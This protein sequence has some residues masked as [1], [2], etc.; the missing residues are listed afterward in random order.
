MN[1]RVLLFDIDGTLIRCGG[2]GGKSLLAAAALEFGLE[3][4]SPVPIHGRTDLGIV[5]QLL[6]ENGIDCTET[7]RHRLCERYYS[8]LP[9][10]LARLAQSSDAYIL[11]GIPSLLEHV[12]QNPTFVVGLLTGNMPPSARIKLEYFELWKYFQFGIFGNQADHRPALA[13]PAMSA[14]ANHCGV[15]MKAKDVSIIGKRIKERE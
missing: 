11:P 9:D 12:C 13:E 3:K 8:L 15:P 7:N 14:I 4:V 2:A 10:R 6:D 1:Q 5:N